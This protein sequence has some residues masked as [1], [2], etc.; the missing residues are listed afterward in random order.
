[1][2]ARLYPRLDVRERAQL[3][4]RDRTA[5]SL[6]AM[7]LAAALV[8]CVR[9]WPGGSVGAGFALL[10]VVQ[11]VALSALWTAIQSGVK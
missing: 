2:A 9:A 8:E 5:L 3:R 7:T 10:L 6:L 1:M 4:R 11:S